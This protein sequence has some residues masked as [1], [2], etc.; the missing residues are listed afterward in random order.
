MAWT[1]AFS[2]S[3]QIQTLVGI[4][5]RTG[6]NDP[7]FSATQA[8]TNTV[9]AL[10]NTSCETFGYVFSS[11]QTDFRSAFWL[12]LTAGPSSGNRPF[13]SYLTITGGAGD[14]TI[15]WDD[16]ITSVTF[17]VSGSNVATVSVPSALTDFNNW[18]NV[19]VTYKAGTSTGRLTFYIN[20]VQIL[21]YTGNVGTGCT[22]FYGPGRNGGGAPWTNSIFFD[23]FYVD[24]GSGES[25]A[26]PPAKRFLFALPTGAGTDTAWTPNTGANYAA[27]DETTLDSDTTY[28]AATTADLRDNYAFGDVT[29]PSGWSVSQVIVGAIAKKTSSI[30]AD[31]IFE[32]LRAGDYGSSA[33]KD[34]TTAYAYYEAQFATDPDTGAA[35]TLSNV[36][37]AQ[38]GY[39]STGSFA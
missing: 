20:G 9:S 29:L 39:K 12:F 10:I 27:V 7:T 33:A 22:A 30:D 35:W 25:D 18:I 13:L 15:H 21:T 32:T 38:Y 31:L 2:W 34:L 8:N 11:A 5:R 19:G 4:S 14:I 1:R 37:D 6:T 23:D 24:V 36:N 16:S 28:V 3:P 17:R 26:A